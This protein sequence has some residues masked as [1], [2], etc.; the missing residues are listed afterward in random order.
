MSTVTTFLNLVKPASLENFSRATYNTNLDLIDAYAINTVEKLAKGGLGQ[1]KNAASNTVTAAEQMFDLEVVTLVQDR[2]Y[3]ASYQCRT[4]CATAAS[5]PVSISFKKSAV[6][7]TSVAGTALDD[8]TII[9]TASVA[10]Q[11]NTQYAV[12]QWKATAS[13]TVN[14]KV[15]TI[16]LGDTDVALSV[17]KLFVKDLGAQ[18]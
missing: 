18:F 15:V 3:E 8:A 17:R 6:A 4:V 16:R 12:I 9:T 10:N 11:G 2:W 7:D 1:N 14:I 13:E 5:K